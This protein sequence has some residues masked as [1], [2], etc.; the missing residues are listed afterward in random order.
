MILLDSNIVI[1]AAKP[2][3]K[4]L[5]DWLRSQSITISDLTKLE[6]LGYHQLADIEFEWF[7][8]FFNNIESIPILNRYY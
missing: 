8:G 3:F 7:T 6:V 5:R 1:Y 4:K 2:E